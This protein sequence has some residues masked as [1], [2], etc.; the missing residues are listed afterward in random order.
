M[1]KD[2]YLTQLT[3][4][5]ATFSPGLQIRARVATNTRA[6]RTGMPYFIASCV[7]YGGIRVVLTFYSRTQMEKMTLILDKL[8][9]DGQVVL[10]FLGL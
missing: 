2:A 7:F 5:Q 3:L 10:A 4:V 8:F 9:V 1:H 6:D